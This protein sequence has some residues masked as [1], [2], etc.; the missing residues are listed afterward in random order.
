MDLT[1]LYTRDVFTLWRRFSN[2][3]LV[4]LQV[5]LFKCS[6]DSPGPTPQGVSGEEVGSQWDSGGPGPEVG[7]SL[8]CAVTGCSVFLSMPPPGIVM[9]LLPPGVGST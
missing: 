3:R 8:L 2:H 9:T 6:L 7:Q 4:P 5:P 1:R